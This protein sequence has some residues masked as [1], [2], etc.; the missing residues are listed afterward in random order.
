MKNYKTYKLLGIIFLVDSLLLIAGILWYA[1]KWDNDVIYYFLIM[2]LIL[3][4]IG[5]LL[6]REGS[7]RKS[8]VNS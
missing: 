5:A 8:L 1:N 2:P 6:L 4:I 7:K 3:F